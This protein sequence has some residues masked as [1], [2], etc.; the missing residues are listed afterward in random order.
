MKVVESVP[1][2]PM[3]KLNCDILEVSVDLP[4]Y[5]WFRDNQ[6]LQ[7]ANQANLLLKQAGKYFVRT[8]NIC[9]Y[10]DS[11]VIEFERNKCTTEFILP[12]AFSPNDDG[13]NDELAIVG[14]NFTGLV[15]L[16]YN[17]W[18]ELV[19]TANRLEDKWDGN[20]NGKPAPS[21]VYV[22]QATMEST[23]EKGQKIKKTGK[24]T[25]IR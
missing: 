22:W 12:T 13:L 24:I 20:L 9:G 8:Q 4:N 3:I 18:G 15:L 2:R 5:Q 7:G 23:V 14:R 19:F 17:R 25:L 6:A 21:G 16:I 1:S 11:E 10:T